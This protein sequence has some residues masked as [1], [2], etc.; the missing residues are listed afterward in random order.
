MRLE[1]SLY[2][3][4]Q[5]ILAHGQAIS[6]LSDN[7]SNVSTTG[8]KRSVVSFGDIVA[9][10]Y[11]GRQSTADA[12]AGN[13]V[14]IERVRPIHEGGTIEFTGRNLDLAIEG[15]GFFVSGTDTQQFYSRAGDF[16]VNKAGELVNS[17]GQTV[18]GFPLGSTDLGVLNLYNVQIDANPTTAITVAGNLDSRSET[19]TVLNS[20]TSFR[21][22]NDGSS[23]LAN[24]EAI[25]SLGDS[26]NLILAYTKTDANT[27]VGQLYIDGADVGGE[28]GV[29][30]QLGTNINLNFDSSGKIQGTPSL[31]AAIPYAGGAA[32]GNIT[33]GLTGF[34]QLAGVSEVKSIVSNGEGTGSVKGFA[35]Q[36]DGSVV[37]QLN[38]GRT[39]TV[40]TLALAEFRNVDGLERQGKALF[41]AGEL[42]G[43]PEYRRPGESG[44]G[45]IA[46]GALE[47]STVDLG[48]ELVNLVLYQKGFQANT[49]AF[50]AGEEMISQGMNL[51]R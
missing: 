43:D 50:Q 33:I 39:A 36:P 37:A 51:K 48:T 15:S 21:Q 20:P 47:L 44:S 9:E 46:G 41:A 27:W 6:V 35:V 32:A 28:A 42:A 25:D 2:S 16:A 12:T 11:D 14:A 34:G 31:V 26:H 13:G 40:G 30:T 3:S 29:P 38:S 24:I 8:F 4:Q 1:S 17:A 5:G 19:K 45:N 49:K 23:F 22:L 7:I 18:L 10:G